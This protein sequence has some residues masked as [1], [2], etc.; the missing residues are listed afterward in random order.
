[1]L[2]HTDAV[3]AVGKVPLDVRGDGHRPAEPV[4]PQDVRAEGHRRPVRPQEGPAR[5]ARAVIDGGGHERGMRS[6]TLPVPL[7]VGFGVACELARQEMP[8]EAKRLL[9][10][11]REAPQGHHASQLP[12]VVPERPSDRAAAGQPEP[13]LRLRRG[14][15]ADDGHQGRGGVER[16]GLHVGQPGAELR[17]ARPWASATTWP[18]PA[19]A[20]A[21]AGSTPRRRSITWSTTWSAR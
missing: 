20:S 21:W 9:R 19:S 17:P 12:E 14:R 15:R 10:A 3:Q 4:G 18:T 2:F 1:M 11:P 16:L 8:T 13:Q 7:I 5:P 6:G